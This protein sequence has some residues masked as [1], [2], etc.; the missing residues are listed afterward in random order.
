MHKGDD[1]DADVLDVSDFNTR[2]SDLTEYLKKVNTPLMQRKAIKNVLSTLFFRDDVFLYLGDTFDI[3]T[4]T[5]FVN[6]WNS[7][8]VDGYL[9]DCGCPHGPSPNQSWTILVTPV[10][11][12]NIYREIL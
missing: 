3:A 1:F 2:F 11:K 6:L 7:A 8:I 9:P 12:K 4:Y 5:Q 10:K